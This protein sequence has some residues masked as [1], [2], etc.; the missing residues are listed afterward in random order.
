VLSWTEPVT[1]VSAMWRRQELSKG[2]PWEPFCKKA[3]HLSM[4]GVR[5]A[6]QAR[7]PQIAHLITWT[8]S[9]LY[10]RIGVQELWYSFP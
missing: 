10:G 7:S 8:W 9:F 3:G 4:A 5:A 2:H 1:A 6:Q